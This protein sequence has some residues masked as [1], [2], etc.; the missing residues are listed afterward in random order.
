MQ[1]DSALFGHKEYTATDFS[2]VFLKETFWRLRTFQGYLVS[3]SLSV[4][5]S[6][7]FRSSAMPLMSH[8]LP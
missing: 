7:S 6:F 5:D 4:F 2:L 1:L 8:V 3:Q